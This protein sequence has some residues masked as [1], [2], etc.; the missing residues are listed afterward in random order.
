MK[1]DHS[2]ATPEQ[3]PYVPAEANPPELT[4]SAVIIGA[5]L[6]IVF[7]ASS[8]YLVLQVGMTVSASIPI[9]VLS[10]TIFRLF[11]P[12]FGRNATIL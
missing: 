8:L 11:T 4:L 7:G 1:T 12:L 10:I 9:A 2:T 3:R 6:G 5:I